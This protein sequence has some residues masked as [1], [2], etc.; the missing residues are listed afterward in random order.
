MS[1]PYSDTKDDTGLPRW[2]KVSGIIAAIV[3]V[4]VVIFMLTGL[5]GEHG[6][7]RH[8]PGGGGETAPASA[9]AESAPADHT[10]P[11]GMHG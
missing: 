11:P 9:P 7:S 6:P 1:N 4:G 5:G 2:V 3:I 8:S 10:P